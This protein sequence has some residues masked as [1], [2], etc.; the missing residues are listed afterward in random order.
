METKHYFEKISANRKVLTIYGPFPSVQAARKASFFHSDANNYHSIVTKARSNG[1]WAFRT[2]GY[3]ENE[4]ASLVQNPEYYEYSKVVVKGA[5]RKH[6]SWKEYGA[7]FV[8]SYF[9]DCYKQ[10]FGVD[11]A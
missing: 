5:A 4:L 6:K 8:E 2:S 9:L 1:R 10:S 11:Y 7:A 3:E